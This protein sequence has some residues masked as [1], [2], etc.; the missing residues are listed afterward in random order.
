MASISWHRERITATNPCG[1][2]PLRRT[3]PVISAAEARIDF[4]RLADAVQI[5]VRL[6]D[7]VI[8]VSQFRFQYW[9][10][11]AHHSR[12]IGLG[13]TWLADF[14]VM[15]GLTYGITKVEDRIVVWP[16]LTAE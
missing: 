16:K 7:N 6:L 2:I 3:G 12:R 9:A 13:I 8:D 15:L 14:L 10:E 1:A 4:Q 5:A 11:N